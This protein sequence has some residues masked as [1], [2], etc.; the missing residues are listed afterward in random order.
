MN[1]KNPRQ[2]SVW[3]KLY[4][5]RTDF[6]F[7]ASR[8]RWYIFSGALMVACIAVILIRGFTLGIDFVG[9]NQYTVPIT[10]GT[11]LADVES[12]AAAAGADIASGQIAG[13]S[14]FVIRTAELDGP[15]S[16]A[17][18]AAIAEESGIDPDQ[19][20]ISE[21]SA[22]W[23]AAVSQ[24]ALI[25]L[26]V[27]LVLVT[28][29]IWIRFEQ[30]MAIGALIALAHDLLLTAGIFALVG[31]EVTPSTLV[32]MLMILG[33]SLYDTVVVFDKVQEN[34]KHLLQTRSQTF[35][36]GAND[37][38]NMTLMRSLNTSLI[39]A[40]PVAGLLF[41]GVG[42][43]GVGTL[44]DLALV[45]F[46]GVLTGTYSSIFLATPVVVDL[47][48]RSPIYR[49]H[50]QKIANKRAG[51]GDDDDEPP[52]QADDEIPMELLDD[53]PSPTG[54][55]SGGSRASNRGSNRPQQRRRRR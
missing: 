11:T 4:R 13:G 32:G 21:V 40:L 52:V 25:A 50:N 1:A 26:A 15:A 12:A 20:S 22:T 55:S 46:I 19:I 9:G 2:L 8:K 47:A 44:K 18:R 37:A 53:T 6:D 45:L 28:G 35:A 54:A 38:V 14:S 23:G 3:S 7:I 10:E 36:E 43:L 41:I 34:T 16:M 48:E 51:I 49:K 24:Q 27:F 17:V 39:G 33:Y 31:F 30:R 42:M 5:G 29:F